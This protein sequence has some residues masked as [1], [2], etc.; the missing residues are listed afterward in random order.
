MPEPGPHKPSKFP[1]DD[2]P[3]KEPLN[4]QISFRVSDRQEE[5]LRRGA[6]NTGL[7][8]G[9]FIRQKIDLSDEDMSLSEKFEY[10]ECL[11]TLESLRGILRQLILRE[12][13]SDT[14]RVE[15]EW[16]RQHL[17]ELL[18]RIDFSLME[19]FSHA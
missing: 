5:L 12:D 18:W 10:S 8:L 3:P 7:T 15:L 17:E 16:I 1:Y 9:S 4:H 14:D 19:N 11:L 6:K 2:L 13:L